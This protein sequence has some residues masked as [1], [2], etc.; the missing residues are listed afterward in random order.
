MPRS[1]DE[2]NGGVFCA[3]GTIPEEH[4]VAA[5]HEAIFAKIESFPVLF[6]LGTGQYR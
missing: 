6:T 2:L 3:E 5:L 4:L 1:K